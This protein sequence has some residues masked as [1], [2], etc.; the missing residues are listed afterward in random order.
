MKGAIRV[1]L[2]VREKKIIPFYILLGGGAV[3]FGFGGLYRASFI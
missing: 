1:N 2:R 3:G